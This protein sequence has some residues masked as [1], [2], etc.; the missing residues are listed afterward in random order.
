MISG[1]RGSWEPRGRGPR[2]SEREEPRFRNQ[3]DMIQVSVLMSNVTWGKWL[4]LSEHPFP[5]LKMGIIR[6]SISLV[7]RKK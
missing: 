4:C 5:K 7:V 3:R 6:N 1:C 2:G